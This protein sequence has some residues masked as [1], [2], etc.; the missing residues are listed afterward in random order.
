MSIRCV[1][2]ADSAIGLDLSPPAKAMLIGRRLKLVMFRDFDRS[3]LG[4]EQGQVRM[5]LNETSD[6]LVQSNW[7]SRPA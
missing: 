1:V 7:L 5:L 2:H 4:Q 3:D 6:Q